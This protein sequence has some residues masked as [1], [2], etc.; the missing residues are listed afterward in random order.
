MNELRILYNLI[1]RSKGFAFDFEAVDR[2]TGKPTVNPLVARPTLLSIATGTTKVVAL[3]LEWGDEARKYLRYLLAQ[4]HLTAVAHYGNYDYPVAH[5]NGIDL[6][7]TKATWSDT[8]L[9][10]WLKAEEDDLGL[11][12]LVWQHL[13]YRM[14]SFKSAA[15][16]EF[17]KRAK[18]LKKELK[19]LP[20]EMR[21][22]IT[23][24]KRE[25]RESLKEEKRAIDAA[26]KGKMKQKDISAKKRSATE[27]M[28]RNIALGITEI[29]EASDNR[30]KTLKEL[31]VENEA[32]SWKVF[33]KYAVDD[34]KQTWRLYKKMFAWVKREKLGRWLGVELAN[35]RESILMGVRG[36]YVNQDMA[37]E[38]IAVSEP[39]L[40]EFQANVFN[41]AKQE[42][43]INSGVQMA[44][45]LYRDLGID[46]L[47]GTGRSK[48]PGLIGKEWGF[49]ADK[50]VLERIDHPIGRAILDFRSV[51]TIFS[52]FMKGFLKQ[53]QE[54]PLNQ[55]R[56]HVNFNST[57]AVTGRWSSSSMT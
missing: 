46:P 49:N 17:A 43:N 8:R 51:H 55:S 22:Q 40:A 48:L 42:F 27:D 11:K 10:C 26:F 35:Y 28:A 6:E 38:M 1:E 33:R 52:N 41:M 9:L 24:M 15:G 30:E 19:R 21:K 7:E 45:V 20:I 16:S 25:L 54:D 53:A 31:I 50:E 34:A 2:E 12:E 3:C 4:P 57:G 32:L 14:Q 13:E 36:S 39:L 47:P 37:R 23:L 5:W 18:D 56:V 44:E 29:E